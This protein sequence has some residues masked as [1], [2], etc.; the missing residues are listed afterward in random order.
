ML[1][2]VI[3][4]PPRL[5]NG[6]AERPTIRPRITRAIYPIKRAR[7]GNEY[8]SRLR[9]RGKLCKSVVVPDPPDSTSGNARRQLVQFRVQVLNS[10]SVAALSLHSGA[11]VRRQSLNC[12]EPI[13][14]IRGAAVSA[15]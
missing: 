4:A 12:K 15:R 5:R 7:S 9:H 2:A 3:A 11:L 13:V 6:S 8:P 1:W 14:S 10:A